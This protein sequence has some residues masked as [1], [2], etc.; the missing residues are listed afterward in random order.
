MTWGVMTLVLA[1]RFWADASSVPLAED[2][3]IVPALTGNEPEFTRWLWSQNNEHRVPLP[4]LVALV[5]LKAAGGDF[6]AVG[7]FNVGLMAAAAGGLIVFLR[8][9]RGGRT[10][11]A[12]AFAPLALLHWGHSVHYLFPFL[13]SLIL[14]VLAAL[15]IG[16]VVASAE[17]TTRPRG[18]FLAGASLLI[19]PLCGLTG[20]LYV[21]VMAAYFGFAGWAC[22]SGRR[23]WPRE[24]T[25]SAILFILVGLAVLVSGLYFIGYYRPWWNP[26]LPDLVS[27]LATALKVLA[28]GFGVAPEDRW[29]PFVVLMLLLLAGTAWCVWRG[30]LRQRGFEQDRA[31]GFVLFLANAVGFA[32]VVGWG[33]AGWVPSF[34][35]PSRYALL[36]APAFIG[37]F[38][39]WELFGSPLLQRWVPRLLALL[40]LV[41]VPWNTRAGDR[42]FA[43]WYREGMTALQQDIDEGAS[44]SELA[45]RHQPFLIHMWTPEQLE[46]GMLWLRQA[47]IAPFDRVPVTR[48]DGF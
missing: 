41:L 26:P 16:C 10:D 7:A 42:W 20:L 39:A 44:I 35:I 36:V 33:R 48:P 27:C 28:L 2:W 37:C 4:R 47:G 14:P 45:E 40:M 34:G 21:P 38:L 31:A 46:E 29:A 43:D 6:R 25:A 19:M 9:R 1:G 11:I 22:W 17:S 24:R 32:F 12:D 8:R 18:A 15:A 23:G 13:L 5:I 3:Y 30:F